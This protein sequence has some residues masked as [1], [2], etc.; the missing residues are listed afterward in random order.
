MTLPRNWMFAGLV[1]LNGCVIYAVEGEG[2][3]PWDWDNDTAEETDADTDADADSDTDAD[4]DTDT[5]APIADGVTLSPNSAPAG[6]TGLVS[7]TSDGTIDL[8]SIAS[9]EFSSSV[10]VLD[11]SLRADELLLVVKV[12]AAANPGHVDVWIT[13]TDGQALILEVPFEV[14]AG[15]G[16][17]DGTD[18]E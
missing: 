15:D 6:D 18:C 12:D 4:T 10:V 9:V 1:L 2:N 11:S 7:V 16:S 13:T 3:D 5:S 17:G 14:T 8:A